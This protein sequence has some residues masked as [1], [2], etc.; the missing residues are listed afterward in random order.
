MKLEIEVRANVLDVLPVGI[1]IINPA[2]EILYYNDY[3]AR[4]VD[5]KPEYI[6]RD[7]RH[8]HK[9][10]KSIEKIDAVLERLR[11]GDIEEYHYKSVRNGKKLKV[12][13]SPFIQDG[14]CMGF[15]QSFIVLN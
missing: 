12:T 15:I 14:E 13:V 9:K 2:G 6:G 10:D 1:T 8:C 3:C 4:Y 11:Q 7:I 5:R